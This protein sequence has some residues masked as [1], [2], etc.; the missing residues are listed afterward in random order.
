MVACSHSDGHIVLY[1]VE[2]QKHLLTFAG[3]SKPVRD[4]CFTSDGKFLISACDDKTCN[5]YDIKS[6]LPIGSLN[7]HEASVLC[8]EQGGL[9]EGYC[10]TGSHDG[11]IKVWDLRNRSC[12]QTLNDHKVAVWSLA[13]HDEAGCLASV[14]DDAAVCV[15]SVLKQ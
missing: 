15:Y 9:S 7:G 13:V 5:L 10:A 8:V 12:T 3:H 11:G 2:T 14:S 4:L 1:D 6:K